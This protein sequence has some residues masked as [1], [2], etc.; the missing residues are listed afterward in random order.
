MIGSL[1]QQKRSNLW[2]VFGGVKSIFWVLLLTP[3]S[4]L[5]LDECRDPQVIVGSAIA[6]FCSAAIPE[7][8][9]KFQVLRR[10]LQ[11]TKILM[12]RWTVWC[13][14]WSHLL[15]LRRLRMYCTVQAEVEH[16]GPESLY[17]CSGA[18]FIWRVDG[19]LFARR[20]FA[21]KP[22]LTARLVLPCGCPF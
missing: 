15:V 14:E 16:S 8:F 9:F 7:E 13:T 1:S 20:H 6:A 17:C 11:D 4:I 22:N 3:L 10:S 21:G 19:V 12:N 18:R 5:F 2:M